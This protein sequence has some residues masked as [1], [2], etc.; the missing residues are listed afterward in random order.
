MSLRVIRTL[1]S[2]KFITSSFWCCCL[3]IGVLNN[4]LFNFLVFLFLFLFLLY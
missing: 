4:F 1:V 3:E 2:T